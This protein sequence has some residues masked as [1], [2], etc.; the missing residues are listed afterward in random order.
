MFLLLK[1][2]SYLV[3]IYL[4]TAFISWDFDIIAFLKSLDVIDRFFI[5]V[6]TVGMFPFYLLVASSYKDL[7][8]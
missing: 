6:L 4:V 7:E 1:L 2:V 3:L 5:L 8:L